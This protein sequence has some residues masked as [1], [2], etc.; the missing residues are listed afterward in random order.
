MAINNTLKG[1]LSSYS[2]N[3]A[4]SG[5]KINPSIAGGISINKQGNIAQPTA[6][7]AMSSLVPKVTPTT[8]ANYN[9]G[10]PKLNSNIASGISINQQGNMA[11]S[12]A[13]V[14]PVAPTT[15]SYGGS[16][17]GLQVQG[18]TMSPSPGQTQGTQQGQDGTSYS[19]IIRG[20]LN[21]SKPSGSQRQ[22]LEDL[23][24]AANENTR[25]GNNA[26]EIAQ[27]Y[28]DEIGRVGKLGA[29]A[30]AGDMSTGTDVVGS[31]NAALASQSASSRI[32]ALS[33]AE[34]AQLQGTG[35]QLTG[36]GQLANA[37]NAALGGANTQQQQQISGL[38]SAAGY[39]QPSPA[40]YGQTVFNPLEGVFN[41]GGGLPHEVMDQYAQMAA[42]GQYDG[43]PS[44]VTSNPV[45]SA[46][47]NVAAKALNPNFNPIQSQAAGQVLGSVP[48]MQS[49][50]TAAEGIKNTIQSYLQSNPTINANDLAAGNLLQQWIDGKQLANPKYQVLFNYLNEY[51]NT[52]APVLGVG[53]DPTN[54]KTQIAQSFI[55][56]AASGQSI[57]QVLDAMS[58]LATNKIAD[59][60]S[61]ALGGG[62]NV[63]AP[64][65]GGGG[66]YSF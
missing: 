32:N 65:G 23:Q 60:Q 63:P 62:T 17:G 3:P 14:G 45:L 46:Q 42:N 7:S 13:P 52:L 29:G 58:K 43:I 18:S 47:L 37:L 51:T 31:G 19:T 41:E 56:A 24:N 10:Q 35:Q 16:M 53:G 11:P 1:I 54:F 44:F 12:M 26:A 9:A 30:V 25:I 40:A 21:A 5:L 6:S 57:S 39:T 64:S 55:N 4:L 8:L 34:S 48:A 20:L 22:L 49:A 36:Q 66:L 38:G 28:G 33:N 27:R 59:I 2:G 15:Q 61:G 50:N